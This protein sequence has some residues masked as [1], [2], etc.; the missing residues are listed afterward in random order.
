MAVSVPHRSPLRSRPIAVRYRDAAATLLA[1][2]ATAA[3]CPAVDPIPASSRIPVTLVG[4]LTAPADDPMHMPTDVA[5]D[6]TGRAYVADGA[7]DRIVIFRPDGQFDRPLT[8]IGDQK[9]NRPVG[10]T[11]DAADQLWIA[12]TGNHRIL[13]VARDGQLLTTITAPTPADGRPFEPTDIAVTADGRRAYFPDNR[14]HRIGIRDN[15]TGEITFLGKFGPGLGQFRWPF[16]TAIAPDGYLYITEAI[17]SRA[18]RLSPTDRWAGQVGRWGV[19]LGQLYRPK[20]VVIDDAKRPYVGDSTLG[21][22]QVFAPLGGV[23]GVLTDADGRPFKF[24]HP[25]GLTLDAQGRLYVVE[26]A[27]NRVAILRLPPEYT[28]RQPAAAPS[29]DHPPTTRPAE[30]GGR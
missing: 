17:G 15:R 1:V 9:L 28:P 6:S 27:A 10:L 14:N 4:T 12:D 25:M 7:R 8:A 16:M 23:V 3:V 13:L 5:L 21:V 2:L 29:S 30:E 22:V 11:V 20:G 26:L 19:E 24:Q 18:Q